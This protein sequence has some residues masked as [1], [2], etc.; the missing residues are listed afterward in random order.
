VWTRAAFNP[1]FTGF[2]QFTERVLH[3]ALAKARFLSQGCHAGKR[4]PVIISEV[5]DGQKQKQ[6]AAFLFGVLPYA[7]HHANAHFVYTPT[8]HLTKRSTHK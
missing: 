8:R 3:G 5:R 1:E 7:R 4:D 2:Q 6:I